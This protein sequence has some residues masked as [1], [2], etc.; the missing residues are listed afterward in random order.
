[1]YSTCYG[2]TSVCALNSW[3]DFHLKPALLCLQG[4]PTCLLTKRKRL[5]YAC[6]VAQHVLSTDQAKE[7]VQN[8]PSCPAFE[9]NVKARPWGRVQS[10]SLENFCIGQ[11]VLY[12]FPCFELWSYTL[13][14][15]IYWYVTRSVRK[16][17]AGRG[18]T[19]NRPVRLGLFGL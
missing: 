4:C 6:M 16:S 15:T 10:I 5:C 8:V 3:T 14:P 11:E 12:Q 13:I 19:Y 2:E 18:I 7:A 9:T 17:L 1:M